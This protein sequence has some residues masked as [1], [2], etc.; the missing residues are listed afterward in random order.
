MGSSSSSR[1]GDSEGSRGSLE[2]LPTPGDSNAAAV[3][4]AM[5]GGAAAGAV[6]VAP[7]PVPDASACR[8]PS[9]HT[10]LVAASPSYSTVDEAAPLAADK[11]AITEVD[12]SV[13]AFHPVDSYEDAFGG[14]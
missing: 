11:K 12:T 14:L 7:V 13:R 2:G 10:K 1:A 5:L 8:P 9:P 3:G 4:R 6:P